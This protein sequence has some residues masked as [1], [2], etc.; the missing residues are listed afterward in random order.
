MANDWEI[1]RG[2]GRCAT[3]GR[4]LAE[5]E[6]YYTALFETAEAF[7]R[8]DYSLEGWSGPPEGSFCYWKTRMPIKGK[9][10]T[11]IAVDNTLLVN[12]FCRLE[13]DNS[14]MRQKFRF[15]LALLLMRKRLLRLDR[16]TRDDDGRELWHMRLLA[17]QSTHQ[18]LNPQLSNEEIDRLSAQLAAILSGDASVISSLEED[19]AA[20]GAA[21]SPSDASASE[22]P[23]SSSVEATGPESA[24]EAS[25]ETAQDDPVEPDGEA[26]EDPS[27][28]ATEDEGDPSDKEDAHVSD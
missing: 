21:E 24:S 3:T 17:E 7:E 4:E 2:S 18:V 10:P 12:L 28:I 1:S 6:C 27:N 14:E 25:T 11:A 9:K 15:V 22:A 13:D 5:G 26:G 16:T 20:V 23:E 8:R 19:E